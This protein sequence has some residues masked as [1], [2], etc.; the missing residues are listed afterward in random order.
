MADPHPHPVIG[1]R[2]QPI[3]IP[4]IANQGSAWKKKKWEHP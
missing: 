2:Y 1:N 3:L 4:V